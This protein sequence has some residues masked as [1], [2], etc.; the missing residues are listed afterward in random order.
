MRETSSERE[1]SHGVR[2]EVME[3]QGVRMREEVR[4]RE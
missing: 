2:E 1:E 3:R 4:Q